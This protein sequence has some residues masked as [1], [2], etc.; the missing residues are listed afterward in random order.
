MGFG[1]EATQTREYAEARLG[2]VFLRSDQGHDGKYFFV[3]ANDPWVLDPDTNAL[4]IERPLYRS[5][6]MLYPLLAG[7]GGAFSPEVIVWSL[8]FVN[9]LAM[10]AGTWATA[11][12]AQRLGL[13]AWWGLAFALNPGF[14]SELI[15]DG[16]GILAAAA[17]FAAVALILRNRFG[18]GVALLAASAL[19]R[20]VML[21]AALGTAWWLWKHA[22][23]RRKAVVTATVPVALVG[24]WAL[25]VRWRIGWDAGVSEVQ[26]IGLPFVGFVQAAGAWIGD[27]LNVATGFLL[28]ALLLVFARRVVTSQELV[29]WAFLGFVVLGVLF[30][31]Q[32]WANYFDITRAVAPAITA[33][34]ILIAASRHDP[35]R[36]GVRS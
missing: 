29:G 17:A 24:S 11:L 15:I 32:V 5:Q 27:P 8:L 31:E 21:I 2:P 7:A 28:L 26:E 30:T 18:W 20:E 9:V 36:T 23:E 22:D 12:I 1:E 25:Y 19:T 35:K 4:V 6:R 33:F 16:A 10:G 34:V 14:I 13:S 3:Q